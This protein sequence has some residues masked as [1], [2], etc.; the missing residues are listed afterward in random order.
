M[1]LLRPTTV[2]QL[3]MLPGTM[4]SIYVVLVL[5]A[6]GCAGED[7]PAATPDAAMRAAACT[8][9]VYDPCTTADQCGSGMCHFFQQSNFTVCSQTC[10]PNDNSTCP[11][12]ASGVNGTCNNKGICKPAQANNCSR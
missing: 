5:A 8:N 6:F 11:V 9:A 7:P 12:D 10:T 1:A 4:K 3:Q 2:Q